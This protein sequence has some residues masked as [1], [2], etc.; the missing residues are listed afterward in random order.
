M[1]VVVGVGRA[2]DTVSFSAFEL[3]YN[4]KTIRGTYYGTANIRRDFPRLLGLWRSGQL[5]LEGMITRRLEI[6]D[7]NDAFTAMQA[8]DVIRQ[9]ITFD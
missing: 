6:E 5:D 8:G 4:E 9:V 3:F 2:E 7:I 1:T